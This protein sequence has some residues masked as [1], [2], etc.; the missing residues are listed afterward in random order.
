VRPPRLSARVRGEQGSSIVEGLLA[1]GL[2]TLAFGI[3]V[4]AV[5]VLQ[6]RALA[7]AAAEAGARAGAVGGSGPALEA[8]MQVLDAGGALGDGFAPS[9]ADDGDTVTASVVGQPRTIF[10]LGIGLPPVTAVASVPA[11]RYPQSE[12]A[13]PG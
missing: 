11:E 2:V 4:Q 10:S 13:A 12:Q 3:G 5:V 9:F 7:T 6:S 1:L 8:A